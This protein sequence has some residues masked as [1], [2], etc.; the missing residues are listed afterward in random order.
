MNVALL[1]DH[2]TLGGAAQSASRL[3]G[4][5]GQHHAVTRLVGF[6]DGGPHGWQTRVLPPEE[7]AWRRQL[8]R[9]PRRLW[10][11]RFPRPNTAAFVE[12]QLTDALRHL[13]PDIINL[14]NLHGAAPWGWGPR[15]A[16]IAARFAPVVWTLHDM[17][18][19]TGRCAY[20]Y[21]C[22]RFETGCT[23]ECPTPN[24][25]PTLPAE[26]IAHAWAERALL[27]A[28]TPN[29][30]AVAPSRW[31]AD[32]ARRGA[33]AGR[34]VEV[35]PYG[36]PTDVFRP[37]PR[38]DARQALGL[39]ET[40]HVLLLA[41]CDLSERRKGAAIV[42]QLGPHL[43]ER[44]FTLLTMGRGPSPFAGSRV[45]VHAL[46]WIDD[47]ATKALAFSAADALL[48]P[49]PVDNLPNVVLE[50]LACGTPVIALP[51]GG[52]PEMVR[53]GSTGW[54]AATATPVALAAALDA[55]L[56][57]LD[58]GADFRGSCR[59]VAETEYTLELQ[60]RRYERLFEELQ[61]PRPS[62]TIRRERWP[63]PLSV[64]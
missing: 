42:S 19:F 31:L 46:G 9:V 40:G 21:E 20:S 59:Y 35:I 62:V 30:A 63:I 11:A 34:R 51:I 13:R 2:E 39:P 50:A 3:A 23:S 32:E 58:H 17:W 26:Q 22:R 38:R 8:Y 25:P 44:P 18:S 14:H 48:H 41:A 43:T 4:A 16:A 1:S 24:E 33:W 27:L 47:D 56:A 45:R 54:L 6:A 37:A 55:A 49:A 57:A 29:L 60:A 10:P 7:P 5:L 61:R 52:V 53:P 12:R 15:L 28:E 36:V 64:R